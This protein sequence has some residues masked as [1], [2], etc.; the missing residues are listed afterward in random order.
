MKTTAL[1]ALNTLL[2]GEMST[3]ELAK[4][5]DLGYEMATKLVKDLVEQGYLTKRNTTVGL[6]STAIA[7]TYRRVS[8]KYDTVKLLGESREKVLLALFSSNTVPNI[9]LATGLSY[10]TIRRALDALLETGAIKEEKRRY[11][12]AEDQELRFFLSTLREEKHRR[13]VEPYAEVVYAS[14]SIMLKRIPLGKSAEGSLTGFSV[15]S[16]YGVE[17]TTLFQYLVQPKR[18]P[19]TEEVLIH[20]MVFSR[21]PVE[22]TD[23][24]IF[25]I[26][27]KDSM[28][29]VKLRRIA[30]EFAVDDVVV[31]LGNYVRNPATPSLERFLP[32]SEF[33]EKAKLYGISPETLVPPPAFPT[34]FSELAVQVG[35]RLSLYL[36]GGEAMRIRGLKRATKDVDI[37]VESQKTAKAL[38]KALRALGYQRL[39]KIS[40]TDERLKPTGIYVKENYPRVDLFVNIICNAF[41]LSQPIKDRCEMKSIDSLR[42]FLMSNED[43]FLL[44]SIT[45]RE[46]DIYDMIDLAKSTGFKWGVVFEELLLQE[47]KTG[48][49][50]C[51]PLLDSIEVIEK[52]TNIRAPF[53]NKLLNHCI[54]QTIL[55][56]IGKWKATTLKQI[57]ELVKYPD[58]KLRSRI[59]H[60]IN[61]REVRVKNGR[62]A[63]RRH[64]HS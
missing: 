49:N 29:L 47:Q 22:L 40:R 20:A 17:V 6:A 37:V 44:K 1:R 8:M 4:A 34:L 28:D 16:M 2:T 42:L 21:N 19:S 18:E 35:H 58:Y 7:T 9:Q 5:I 60:L 24:A 27:N 41:R 61:E 36:F 3:K 11:S 38:T 46:G 15:F 45:D 10:R 48:R 43:I 63:L 62:L 64:G 14:H 51:L 32:W 25:Y 23:C 50:F 30:K 55:K 53:Y 13:L 52:K 39:V 54:D 59:N 57:K 33:A 56:S 31:D 26:K 12:I